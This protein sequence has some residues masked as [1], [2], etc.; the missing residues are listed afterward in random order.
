MV[1]AAQCTANYYAKNTTNYLHG[2]WTP[3][4]QYRIYRNTN[5]LIMS[6]INPIPSTDTYF[7]KF[8]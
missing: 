6:Q 1:I 7:F 8:Y 5:N 4:V 3:E 2:S